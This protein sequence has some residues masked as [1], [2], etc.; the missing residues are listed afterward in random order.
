[1]SKN[2]NTTAEA[3]TLT[4]AEKKAKRN[5]YA[6]AYYAQHKEERKEAVKKCR[7]KKAAAE[8]KAPAAK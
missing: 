2:T 7:A 6:R 8:G 3:K 5:L 4:E 1:M